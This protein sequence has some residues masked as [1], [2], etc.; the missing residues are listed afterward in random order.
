MC[1]AS[2]GPNYGNSHVDT[3]TAEYIN[4]WNQCSIWIPFA[5]GT[6]RF[7]WSLLVAHWSS[8]GDQATIHARASSALAFATFAH[9]VASSSLDSTGSGATIY[10]EGG[11][12]LISPNGTGSFSAFG[13][14][15]NTTGGV[16]FQSCL[17]FGVGNLLGGIDLTT[18]QGGVGINSMCLGD[19]IE[20]NAPFGGIS[21]KAG[22]GLAGV[23]GG[24][25][26]AVATT[27]FSF[28]AMSFNKITLD[29]M[30]INIAGLPEV[31]I[32]GPK[33]TI[34]DLNATSLSVSASKLA[35]AT[36]DAVVQA[37]KDAISESLNS[38]AKSVSCIG[39]VS[40]SVLK[41]EQNALASH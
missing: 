6:V 15:V 27:P 26:I 21:L 2:P 33:T 12:A 5:F 17:G 41:T 36:S 11:V 38:V 1:S 18:A 29:S 8:I 28:T 39:T 30:G 10:G 32:M 3:V 24:V 19:E 25:E 23:N 14:G 34:A 4:N 9:G 37:K 22:Q 20:I 13:H 7:F 40:K 31:K 16:D 35:V